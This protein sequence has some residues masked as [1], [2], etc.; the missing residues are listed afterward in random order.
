MGSSSLSV[1]ETC[2]GG[3]GDLLRRTISKQTGKSLPSTYSAELRSFALTLHFY[4]PH[5]YRYIRKVFNTCLPH[6]RTIEK[7]Y[8][9]VEGQPGF[10]DS[11]FQAL[12]ARSAASDKPLV[13]ALVFDE[14][15]IRQ[16]LQWDGTQYRGFIDMGTQTNDDSLPMAKEALVFMIVALNDNFKIPVGYFLI[17][18]LGGLERKNLVLQC[19]TRLYEAGVVVPSVTFDGAASNLAMI[20]HLGCN[21]ED[22]HNNFKTFFSHPVTTD[23]VVV[24]L[25]PCHML[26]LVRNTLADKKSMVDAENEFVQF[27]FLEKLHNLQE[28]EGLH[29]GNKLRAA[30][31]Q[32]YRKKMNVK[33][34]AQLLSSS[35]AT[36]LEFCV[37]QSL[38]GFEGCESTIKFIQMFN[39]LFDI[40]NSRNLNAKGFKAPMK[41]SNVT[42]FITFLTNAIKYISSLKES[43]NGRPLIKSNRKTGFLGFIISIHSLLKLYEYLIESN[44]FGMSFLCT[45]KISQDHIELLFGKMRSLGGSNNNPSARQF[46]AGYKRL[47]VHNEIQDVLKGNCLSLQDIPILTVSSSAGSHLNEDCPSVVAINKSSMNLKLIDADEHTV[48]DADYAYILNPVYISDCAEQIVAYIAGFVVHKLRKVLR[49]E[50][51][52]ASLSASEINPVHF[53]ILKK[54]KGGLI[55]PSQDV[56][57]ICITCEKYFRKYVYHVS[58]TNLSRVQSHRIVSS[59]LESY[60]NNTVVF[61]S[62]HNHMM[63][64]EPLDNHLILLIKAVCEKYLQVRYYYAGKQFSAKV[65]YSK[66]RTSRQQHT[67]LILFSGM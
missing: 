20:N 41:A 37:E 65:K 60:V 6:P 59:V 32:W 46:A 47:L 54:S 44:R 43:R 64:C 7:W 3:V 8:S 67:K 33:L 34:A 1:L 17:D 21:I 49:C 25:D 57:D 16:E 30:H 61:S 39:N 31:L 13:C 12:R 56:I 4:S 27:T 50:I 62:L 22:I 35:V 14:M 63:E 28:S 52:I 23:P 42:E 55:N 19:I 48:Q 5:A 36:S 66:H 15:A 24:F 26:K 53:L 38:P 10:T 51:C 18:G 29:L 11:V 45:Y 9:S 40:F 58:S 2:A